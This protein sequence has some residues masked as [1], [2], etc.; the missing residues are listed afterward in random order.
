MLGPW[1]NYRVMSSGIRLIIIRV[2]S[3]IEFKKR[4]QGKILLS[5]TQ[6]K[7]VSNRYIVVNIEFIGFTEINHIL[8]QSLLIRKLSMI[9]EMVK[10][11]YLLSQ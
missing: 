10:T 7:Y 5:C 4:V 2:V 8:D 9:L 1:E 11:I 6:I 3:I